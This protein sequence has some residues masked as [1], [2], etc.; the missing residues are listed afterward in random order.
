MKPH[1]SRAIA[2][3]LYA[4]PTFTFRNGN[5]LCVA[6]RRVSFTRYRMQPTL[7]NRPETCLLWKKVNCITFTASADSSTDPPDRPPAERGGFL[8][9]RLLRPGRTRRH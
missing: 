8:R 4:D 6:H 9:F 5:L 3:T 2:A 7:P 1:A